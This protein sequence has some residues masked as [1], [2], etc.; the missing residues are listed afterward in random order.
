MGGGD[1]LPTASEVPQGGKG[2][3]SESR[4]T[5]LSSP[6]F[7]NFSYF[8]CNGRTFLGQLWVHGVSQI[9]VFSMS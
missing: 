9:M 7:E 5:G 3:D 8:Y 1:D 4:V 6:S 2:E